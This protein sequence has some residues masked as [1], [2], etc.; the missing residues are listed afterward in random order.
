MLLI[1]QSKGINI[2]YSFGPFK[3]VNTQLTGIHQFLR[4]AKARL[5]TQISWSAFQIGVDGQLDVKRCYI[6]RLAV[7]D[8]SHFERKRLF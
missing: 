5:L 8:Q 4:R 2:T 3:R 1:Q 6:R 7:I